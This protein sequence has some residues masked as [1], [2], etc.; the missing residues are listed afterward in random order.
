M[1]EDEISKLVSETFAMTSNPSLMKENFYSDIEEVPGVIYNLQHKGSTFVLRMIASENL[2][3]DY[4][5]IAQDPK[6]YK[7]LRISSNEDEFKLGHFE[8]DSISIA[9]ALIKQMAKKR[10][11]LFEEHMLNI[12]DPGD[13]WWACKDA[14]KLTVYFK[15]SKTENLENMIKIGPLG[16]GEQILERFKS[17]REVF[18]LLFPISEF[19]SAH[20]SLSV[21]CTNSENKF[22]V[23]LMSLFFS[24]DVGHDF[25]IYLG[26]LEAHAQSEKLRTQVREATYLL[27]E[28]SVLRRFWIRIEEELRL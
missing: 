11:P 10:F 14:G 26:Q 17:L 5:K 25:W 2:A 4:P 27:M 15:L 16:D 23:D 1:F 20:G 28:L 13:S 24:G 12:S 18:G 21:E 8:C 6:S 19:Y 9:K 22:F 7:E 3:E